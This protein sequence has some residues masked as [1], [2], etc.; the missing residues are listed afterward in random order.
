[1]EIAATVV[2]AAV[3]VMENVVAVEV[4]ETD[5]AVAGAAVADAAATDAA[6]VIAT[7]TAIAIAIES[8]PNVDCYFE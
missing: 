7:V 4:M 6:T 2:N 5:A 8:E 1:M 3:M